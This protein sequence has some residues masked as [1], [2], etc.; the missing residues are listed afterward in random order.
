MTAVA[1]FPPPPLPGAI[2]IEEVPGAPPLPVPWKEYADEQGNVYY[3][4]EETLETSWEFP[5]PKEKKDRKLKKSKSDEDAP[6]KSKKLT[7]RSSKR[8][9]KLILPE[10][11]TEVGDEQGNLYYYNEITGES[12][13]EFPAVVP[14]SNPP[15]W[16]ECVHEDGS[17]YYYNSVTQETSWERPVLLAT[18]G[19]SSSTA[20]MRKRE[21]SIVV[22]ELP[23][24]QALAELLNSM[25]LPAPMDKKKEEDLKER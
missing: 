25:S 3:Y 14:G 21:A 17:V 10:N 2:S 12:S 1:A 18:V 4:N 11:W 9:S 16:Q 20:D 13:W 15:D 23:S 24:E 5:K 19:S 7:K 8:S 22:Q 6:R